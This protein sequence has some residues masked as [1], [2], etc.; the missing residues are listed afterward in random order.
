MT[1]VRV[2]KSARSTAVKNFVATTIMMAQDCARRGIGK[3]NMKYP[4]GLGVSA[5]EFIDMVESETNKT[6]YGGTGCI[7]QGVITFRIKD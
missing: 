5:Y 2:N 3:F 7:S 1:E 6:V 4:T